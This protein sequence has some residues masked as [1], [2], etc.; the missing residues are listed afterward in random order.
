[1]HGIGAHI[2][3]GVRNQHLG[4]LTDIPLVPLKVS[5]K[6]TPEHRVTIRTR[7]KGIFQ[8]PDNPTPV[9][10]PLAVFLP[11]WLCYHLS[12]VCSEHSDELTMGSTARGLLVPIITIGWPPGKVS[13]FLSP[14][15]LMKVTTGEGLVVRGPSLCPGLF[16]LSGNKQYEAFIPLVEMKGTK[17]GNSFFFFFN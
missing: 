11:L 8:A 5:G 14:P 2:P 3:S 12:L 7:R 17:P 10:T 4:I 16:L 9:C 15:S 6:E 13:W 1:M